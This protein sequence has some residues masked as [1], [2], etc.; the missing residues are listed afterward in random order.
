MDTIQLPQ[1][2][3]EFFA[4]L[5][6][7]KV[8]YLL[9]GAWALALHGCPRYTG[10]M[11]IWIRPTLENAEALI[12]A[13][14]Q[15]GF[16][17]KEFDPQ[18]FTKEENIFRFGFPPMQVDIINSISGVDFSSCCKNIIIVR[19]GDVSINVIGLDDFKKNKLASGR[20]KD[21]ADADSVTRKSK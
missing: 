15:F 1:A 14:R 7:E 17:S 12:R 3:L 16:K 19:I 21:I 20:P 11:D 10:D 13:L 8:D 4:L 5:N 6:A 9:V 2:F 18:A